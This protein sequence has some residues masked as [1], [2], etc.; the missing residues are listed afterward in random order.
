MQTIFEQ[1][2]NG[3]TGNKSVYSFPSLSHLEKEYGLEHGIT[4]TSEEYF[5]K[6]GESLGESI[7]INEYSNFS[8]ET[9]DFLGTIIDSN[10]SSENAKL[11]EMGVNLKA[12]F[13]KV[14]DSI[15][16]AIKWLIQAVVNFLKGLVQWI[17]SKTTLRHSQYYEDN[18]E[19]IG[20]AFG[21][22]KNLIVKAYPVQRGNITKKFKDIF[23]AYIAGNTTLP[24][25][26]EIVELY[27]NY[28]GNKGSKNLLD[29]IQDVASSSIIKLIF[30]LSQKKVNAKYEKLYAGIEE[31]AFN[32]LSPKDKIYYMVYGAVDLTTI[33]I[34][35]SKVISM[36]SF[37]ICS[38]SA[39]KEVDILYKASKAF[40]SFLNKE[41]KDLKNSVR[42]FDRKTETENEKQ[43]RKKYLEACIA[44]RN[45]LQVQS[46]VLFHLF[47]QFLTERTFV[48]KML[49]S[50]LK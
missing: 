9:L 17:K 30:N 3:E 34:E 38:K 8:L 43:E 47:S 10:K 31:E 49:H 36:D 50:I 20:P 45:H 6:V 22:N 2:L 24:Q 14:F 33:D 1:V 44:L 18:K 40:I 12:G 23:V 37:E 46:Q 26:E 32:E 5:R 4:Y 7:R 15:I 35:L 41:N 13:K 48:S 29:N 28:A 19:K 16:N 39:I 11:K 27:L 42:K 21:K 25:K